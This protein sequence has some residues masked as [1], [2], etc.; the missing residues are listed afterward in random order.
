MRGRGR[1]A[2]TTVYKLV[3]VSGELRESISMRVSFRLH[4]HHGTTSE[5]SLRIGHSTLTVTAHQRS[6]A[7]IDES[8]HERFYFYKDRRFCFLR[9]L[10]VSFCAQKPEISVARELS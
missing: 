4:L 3:V 6:A 10:G 5:S 1:G 8:V 7:V 2:L 9:G